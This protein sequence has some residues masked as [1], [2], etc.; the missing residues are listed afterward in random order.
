RHVRERCGNRRRRTTMLERT[1]RTA[2]DVDDAVAERAALQHQRAALTHEPEAACV[3]RRDNAAAG[4]LRGQGV[5]QAAAGGERGEMNDVSPLVGE[6]SM[7]VVGASND[8][9]LRFVAAG[10]RRN[11]IAEHLAAVVLISAWRGDLRVGCG[12][13]RLM[14][15]SAK[16][17]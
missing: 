15:A 7:E 6:R 14:P 13:D 9:A 3:A 1:R 4:V 5:R 2:L 12:D 17:S 11:R 10:G 8:A 16:L